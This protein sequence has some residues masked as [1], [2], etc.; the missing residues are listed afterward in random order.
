MIRVLTVL[1]ALSWLVLAAPAFATAQQPDYIEIDGVKHSLHTNPLSTELEAREW[2]PPSD[3][4]ASSG[5]WRGYTAY[6]A[7]RNRR[8]LLLDVEVDVWNEKNEWDSRSILGELYEQR[9]PI[10]A[11]WY[12]GALIIPDGDRVD[13]VHMGYGSTYE[14]YRI[15]RIHKGKVLEAL[16]LDQSEF[17][18]YRE[19]KFAAWRGTPEFRAH[20]NE[21]VEGG[22][23]S[24]D[25]D[26]EIIDFM[27]AF[28]A[29]VYLAK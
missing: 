2:T 6:W 18:D 7:V 22:E 29:E 5:N 16:S 25:D 12:S 10:V 20:Y 13:Y 9:P 27:K 11:S 26:E 17:V 14:R 3:V 28:F 4:I 15:F 1:L 21:L 8:L 19:Q 24:Q 23:E